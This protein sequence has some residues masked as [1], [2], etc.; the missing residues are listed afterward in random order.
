MSDALQSELITE[1]GDGL[2]MFP[3]VPDMI[4]GADVEMKGEIEFDNFLR[5]DGIFEGVLKCNMGSIYVGKTGK[6]IANLDNC[7]LVVVEGQ[8]IGNISAEHIIF[9]GE[10]VVEGDVVG[11]SVEMGP[12]AQLSGRMTVKAEKPSK[13]LSS[14]SPLKNSQR[15]NDQRTVLL[16][17]DPQVDFHAKGSIGI[18]GSD[19]DAKRIASFI[20]DNKA[21]IDEIYVSMD[22]HHRMHIAHGAFW[23]DRVGRSPPPYTTILN[24]DIEGG[25][26]L[27]RDDA[28]DILDYCKYYTN[29]FSDALYVYR[30]KIS[31]KQDNINR[32]KDLL[33]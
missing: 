11:H 28:P 32:I 1:G 29:E 4:V 22:A 12:H 14:R 25:L 10:A 18:P 23:M 5:V 2:D 31:K 7:D 16:I 33:K 17:V 19:E 6:V 24:K 15:K 26:W 20:T 13:S 3:G 30:F 9:R 8:V 21:E 27:P